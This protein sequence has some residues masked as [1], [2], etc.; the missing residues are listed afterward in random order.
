MALGESVNCLSDTSDDRR[1]LTRA[2]RRYS[3]RRRACGEAERRHDRAA[4]RGRTRR[5][6]WRLWAHDQ[7]RV[8]VVGAVAVPRGRDRI[9]AR[10]SG[11]RCARVYGIVRRR[12]AV[13]TV[14]PPDGARI[15]T[16]R[17]GH[18]RASRSALDAAEILIRGLWSCAA[19]ATWRPTRRR[20]S[21]RRLASLRRRRRAGRGRL[22]AG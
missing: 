12:P 21:R 2:A 15:G 17:Q 16:V 3:S 11:W 7:A 19:T 5:P 18:C 9:L 20:R 22:S 14:H 4:R 13:A 1:M 10:G 6:R 8:A